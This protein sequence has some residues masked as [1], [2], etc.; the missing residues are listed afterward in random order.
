MSPGRERHRPLAANP[1]I[2]GFLLGLLSLCLACGDSGGPRPEARIEEP[3]DVELSQRPESAAPSLP[4]AGTASVSVEGGRVTI[5]SHAA[6]RLG[7]LRELAQAVGFSLEVGSLEPREI[8]LVLV[9]VEPE[10]AL[11]RLLEGAAYRLDYTPQPGG[12]HLIARLES[13]LETLPERDEDLT[14]EETERALQRAPATPTAPLADPWDEEA[15]RAAEQLLTE[16]EL[17]GLVDPSPEA[18]LEVVERIRPTGEGEE[19]L[20]AILR[21][22]EDAS[23]RAAAAEQLTLA[24]SEQATR[25]LVDALRDLDPRV[26]VKAIEGLRMGDE[27]VIQELQW[28]RDHPDASVRMAAADAIEFLE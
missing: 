14:A 12:R 7:V 28:L 9:E 1:P 21:R 20:I 3:A 8:T 16:D 25:A 10:L 4:P 13:G 11:A 19:E 15:P 18:R 24:H 22:D 6:P 17:A 5:R 27:T 23:V 2:A 26:V